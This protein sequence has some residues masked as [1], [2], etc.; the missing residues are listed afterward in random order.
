MIIDKLLQRLRGLISRW[1]NRAGREQD[2]HVGSLG[3]SL[4]PARGGAVISVSEAI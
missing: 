1:L 3:P 2:A 4:T